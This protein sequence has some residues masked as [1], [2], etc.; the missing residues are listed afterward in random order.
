MS[1]AGIPSYKPPSTNDPL[2][3]READEKSMAQFQP[4]SKNSALAFRDAD[5]ESV[6]ALSSRGNF[7][8][9]LTS[10]SSVFSENGIE[11][12]GT[13]DND[14]WSVHNVLDNLNKRVNDLSQAAQNSMPGSLDAPE[15]AWDLYNNISNALQTTMRLRDTY[16]NAVKAYEKAY[17][18][19]PA[20]LSD[21]EKQARDLKKQVEASNGNIFQQ[22]W[23]LVSPTEEQQ[24]YDEYIR[25]E[26]YIQGNL[27]Y[28]A[29]LATTG[30]KWTT[31]QLQ[32][33]K[34]ARDALGKAMRDISGVISFGIPEDERQIY[35]DYQAVFNALD[36]KI[37]AGAAFTAN[38]LDSF[39][40]GLSC[41]LINNA[42]K[43]SA[44]YVTNPE[45]KQAF[46]NYDLYSQISKEH[47]GAAF[48]GGI[49]G[50][51][52]MCTPC[53]GQYGFLIFQPKR[54]L[55]YAKRALPQGG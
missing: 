12:L 40:F 43:Q 5:R 52:L 11:S 42:G 45:V 54:H 18:A 53:Q 38:V 49:T 47:P 33:A 55:C 24:Y 39:T 23:H 35:G 22:A 1:N 20:Q 51:L 31:D 3:F 8:G 4:V 41:D 29:Y 9:A 13:D 27:P 37:K 48:A 17:M 15:E 26:P 50:D 28:W 21:S 32:Q 16:Q 14:Y 10:A 30:Q 6:Q 19:Q 44:Q 25:S 34:D 7:T 2:E 46:D 36:N